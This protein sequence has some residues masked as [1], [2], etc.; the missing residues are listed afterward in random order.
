MF[1][2]TITL[3]L[4]LSSYFANANTALWA[5][6][7]SGV[8]RDTVSS[9]TAND[10]QS[11]MSGNSQGGLIGFKGITAKGVQ[12]IKSTEVNMQRGVVILTCVDNSGTLINMSEFLADGV[13]KIS[14]M[15][16]SDS[17]SLYIAGFF[18]KKIHLPVKLNSKKSSYKD[19][20]SF[21]R[22]F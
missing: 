22:I 12:E 17:G 13:I 18:A 1:K 7:V 20:V 6:G 3:L 4:F 16:F 5:A 9:V 19:S 21:S 14:D 15:E 10:S 8:G 11:C 2:I